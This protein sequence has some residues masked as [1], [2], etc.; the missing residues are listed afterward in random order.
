MRYK[1]IT[2][3]ILIILFSPFLILFIMRL[4]SEKHLDDVNPLIKCDKALLKKADVLAVIPKYKNINI[5]D[6]KIWC[7]YISSLNKKLILHGIYHTYNEFLEDKNQEYLD[8]GSKIFEEC[9]N[10]IPLEFKPPQLA[11]SKNNKELI[12]KSY[13]LDKLFTQITRKTY[14]CEDSGLFPN[15]LIDMF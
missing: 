6:N 13:K 8:E 9:F 12:K 3:L 11:I 4:F 10:F 15:W 1:K 5:S 7:N 2:I 14:H